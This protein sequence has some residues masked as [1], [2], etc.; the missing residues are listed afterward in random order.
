LRESTEE[1]DRGS[2]ERKAEGLRRLVRERLNGGQGPEGCVLGVN[3][4]LVF[5][6]S[7]GANQRGDD[8]E[9][10]RDV[11]RYVTTELPGSYGLVYWYD[12]ED[13]GRGRFDGYRVIVIDRG[14]LHDRFDP[15]LSPTDPPVEDGP[16]RGHPAGTRSPGTRRFVRRPRMTVRRAM[17]AVAMV[18]VPLGF[19]SRAMLDRRHDR[20]AEAA[21][22]ARR[23][24]EERRNLDAFAEARRAGPVGASVQKMEQAS[25]LR[26]RYHAGRKGVYQHAAARP[27]ASVPPDPGEPGERLLWE[28]MLITDSPVEFRIPSGDLKNLSLSHP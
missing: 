16:A 19:W 21:Y 1:S 28:S 4:R 25:R 27:W 3:G 26:V 6:C 2:L 20:L 14:R 24:G 22:H 8:H 17:V 15:F 7:G 9:S 12:D 23:E 18:A 10:L 11:L 13:P 5:Q